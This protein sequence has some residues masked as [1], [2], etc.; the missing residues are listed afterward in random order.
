MI[1]Y[2][3]RRIIEILIMMLVLSF[4]VYGIMS[5]TGDPART[6]AGEYATEEDI[7][8]LRESMGLND[9]LVVRYGRYIWG[10]FHG[11]FGTGLFGDDVFE[12]FS[13]RIAYTIELA[14]VAMVITVI[15]AIPLGIIAAVK[16]NSM[17]D[18]T[19]SVIAM[20]GIS[21]PGFWL[22]LILIII[23]AVNLHWLPTSGATEGF[24]SVILPAFCAGFS[25]ASLVMRMTRASMVENL[26]SDFLRT[27]RAKGVSER[28]VILKHT[29]KNALIPIITMVGSQFSILMGGTVVIESVFAWPGVGYH[30]ISSIRSNDYNMV[31][32]FVLLTTI[33]IASV[34]LLVDILYAFVDPRIKARYTGR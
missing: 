5:I 31:T 6:L 7:A 28:S 25:N 12:E 19:L 11:N 33:F 4:I 14:I 30:L 34:L 10:V 13:N 15:I 29:L 21:I 20:A 17:A 8:Q 22:G 32:G 2:V 9:P 23:F 26:H 24:K 1:K 3:A 27:A 18:T 16:Q